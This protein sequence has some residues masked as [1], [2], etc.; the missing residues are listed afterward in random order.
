MAVF[1]C[2]YVNRSITCQQN[3]VNTHPMAPP[4]LPI[5][6]DQE[7]LPFS[8]VSMDFITELPESSGYSALYVVV[9]YLSKAIILIPCNKTEDALSTAAMYHDHVYKRF[10][11]PKV[12]ISDRGPQFASKVCQELCTRLGIDSRMS[13]AYHPQTD[14]QTERMN[15]EI[16]VFLRIY[17][18]SHPEEWHSHLGD[19]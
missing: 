3:K 9:D 18:G 10:G 14:G 16:E 19:L 6:L 1:I 7:M 2:N 12:M 5:R 13:T 11:L 4:L 17:C 8:N 15:R